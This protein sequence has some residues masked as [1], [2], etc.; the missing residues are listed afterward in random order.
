MRVFGHP[1]RVWHMGS[2]LGRLVRD[3]GFR[4]RGIEGF[5]ESRVFT[6]ILCV[7]AFTMRSWQRS[8]V[9]S[10]CKMVMA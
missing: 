3:L 9:C 10:A 8:R 1:F 2:V 6:V 4:C 5:V 7:S